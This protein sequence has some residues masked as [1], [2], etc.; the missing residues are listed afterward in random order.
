VALSDPQS[1]TINTVANPLP[2][3]STDRNASTY[4]KDDGNLKLS[5]SHSYGKRVRR[6]VR[7]DSRKTAADP[8]FPAQNAPYS[9]SVTLVVDAPL[10]GYTVTELKQIVD[11][12]TAWLSAS[13][14]ANLTKVLGGES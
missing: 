1:I 4:S 8:L 13:S 7:I 6:A 5:V 11:G 12:F 3:V 9:A 14:G 10:T 2:R